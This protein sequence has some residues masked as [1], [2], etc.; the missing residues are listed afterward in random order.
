MVRLNLYKRLLR[1]IL[2][3]YSGLLNTDAVYQDIADFIDADNVDDAANQLILLHSLP[4]TLHP[5]LL[6]IRNADDAVLPVTIQSDFKRILLYEG[7]MN[8]KKYERC[9]YYC[10]PSLFVMDSDYLYNQKIDEGYPQQIWL[11]IEKLCL[12][13]TD[14]EDF[15]KGIVQQKRHT[16]LLAYNKRALGYSPNAKVSV[17]ELFSF[18]LS[19]SLHE[20]RPILFHKKL[21][22]DTS[23]ISLPNFQ[24]DKNV[25]YQ[26]YYD[27]Y[28][29]INDWL[30][31]K[32][33]LSA[34]LR[35]YQIVEFLIYRQQMS[36]I[37]K[38]STIKQSFLRSVKTMNKKFEETEKNTI[39]ENIPIV[40]GTLT[41]S[42]ANIDKAEPFILKYYNKNRRGTRAYLYSG[43]SPN[44]TSV[45]ISKFIYDTRCSIVHNKEAEFHISYNNYEEYKE[46]V[47]LM[48]EVHN[49]L[50]KKVW[51]LINTPGSTISY[52]DN[53]R[54][55]LF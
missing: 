10:S 23:S 18:A 6:S 53:R 51:T 50:A 29:A 47:P 40:F 37:I 46:I 55:D 21:F 27:I 15:I 32:D 30:Q 45:G 43:M 35:I 39:V 7:W 5:L 24:Y 41:A 19:A 31:S 34:F 12:N 49:Q 25:T 20:K 26:Q 3:T 36:E 8:G 14:S 44:E 13:K 38:V 48:K 11:Y 4:E 9:F 17:E 16:Y 33:I 28:D 1:H 22:Y 2:I 54:I 52:E 42:P